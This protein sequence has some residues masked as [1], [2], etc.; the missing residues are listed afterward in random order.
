MPF[1]M[2]KHTATV[3][4]EVWRDI[5]GFFRESNKL[6]VPLFIFG[7]WNPSGSSRMESS[8][9][10]MSPLQEF[11]SWAD[12]NLLSANERLPWAHPEAV[13]IW[14]RLKQVSTEDTR[15]NAREWG[16]VQFH[17]TLY[18]PK[19]NKTMHSSDLLRLLASSHQ[20][21]LAEPFRPSMVSSLADRKLV[22][23]D[24]LA[25]ARTVQG[26]NGNWLR[27][28]VPK[29]CGIWGVYVEAFGIWVPRFKIS[30]DVG[31]NKEQLV[32]WQSKENG[33]PLTAHQLFENQPIQSGPQLPVLIVRLSLAPGGSDSP[34]GDGWE[35]RW[36]GS[37]M[38]EPGVAGVAKYHRTYTAT[39]W[40]NSRSMRQEQ[41]GQDRPPS[42]HLEHLQ[43]ESRLLDSPTASLVS[44]RSRSLT[45][46]LKQM[47]STVYEQLKQLFLCVVLKPCC[48]GLWLSWSY[49]DYAWADQ[50]KWGAQTERLTDLLPRKICFFFTWITAVTLTAAVSSGYSPSFW[51]CCSAG[52][53][54]CCSSL[55]HHKIDGGNQRKASGVYAISFFLWGRLP[56]AAFKARKRSWIHQPHV[57]QLKANKDPRRRE[58][59]ESSS[60]RNGRGRACRQLRIFRQKGS[61]GIHLGRCQQQ[62]LQ[63]WICNC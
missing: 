13:R 4:V 49:K 54:I 19:V 34:N 57:S 48:H 62:A 14:R 47:S 18:C 23:D 37:N 6:T 22:T 17:G 3:P 2:Q 5:Q 1:P 10:V 43:P 42:H 59:P 16:M 21:S 41:I 11:C 45:W 24:F 50:W 56:A 32:L 28:K 15:P 31:P 29:L 44:T 39:W 30:M 38:M 61:V 53:S 46:K 25:E 63:I 33:Q 58:K 27:L 51:F 20:K 8:D 26:K 9:Q 60:E 52:S 35:F 36:E 7:S 12:N 55:P 40:L